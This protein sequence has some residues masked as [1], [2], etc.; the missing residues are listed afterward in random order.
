MQHGTQKGKRKQEGPGFQSALQGMSPMGATSSGYPMLPQS[1][2]PT[3]ITWA[4]E[5]HFEVHVTAHHPIVFSP[6]EMIASLTEN[7][8]LN[9]PNHFLWL[10][11]WQMQRQIWPASSW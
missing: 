5:G 6:C 3:F 9:L 11:K 2:D 7:R 1:G 10:L 4:F 8:S